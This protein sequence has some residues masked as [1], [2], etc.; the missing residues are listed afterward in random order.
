VQERPLARD[1]RRLAAIVAA[2]AVGYSRLMGHDE[3]G[4]LARLRE[5]RTLRFDPAVARHGGRLV[6]LTGD[7]A[8]VEFGSA[9]DAL[10]AAIEFQQAMAE[11]NRGQPADIVIQFRIGV[12]LGDLIVDSDD[13][14]GEGVNIAAR[15]EAEASAGGIVISRTVH[16]AVEGRLKTGFDSLGPL[17]LK[18]IRRPVQAHRVIWQPSDWSAPVAP[19]TRSA[20]ANPASQKS[21]PSIAVLPFDNMS[22]DAE[23]DYFAD[24]IVDDLITALSRFKSLFVVARNASFTYKGKTVPPQQAGQELGVRYLL[25]G[26]VRKAADRVRITGQLID[27]ETGAHLWADRF[28]GPLN[29]VF[30]L[31]DRVTT[32]VVG[33][34]VP[35][36]AQAEFDRAKRKKF[37]NLDAYDCTLRALAL[38]QQLSKESNEQMLALYNRAIELDPEFSPPH[39]HAVQCYVNM[40]LHGWAFD[41]D[42]HEAEVRRL[43]GRILAIGQDDAVALST[44]ALGL[45]WVCREFEASADYANTATTINPNLA[46]AWKNRGAISVFRGEPE[47]AIEQLSRASR[48]SPIGIDFY[49][50]QGY[51]ALAYLF[52]GEYDKA[53]ECAKDPCLYLTAWPIG[54]MASAAAHGLADNPAAAR[55]SLRRLCRLNSALQLSNLADFLSFH[56]AE[57]L[58]TLTEG[59]RLAGLEK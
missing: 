23:H 42:Q 17:S 33:A 15:L 16:E 7:G 50:V 5:H 29:D 24:G 11:I 43:A 53:A 36:L 52:E 32:S 59:L 14:Y 34:I 12:H 55:R 21:L 57:D 4:T 2:D 47:T 37:E 38:S 39:G 8:L 26:S 46:I 3:S 41:K 19:T 10:A 13:L 35:K 1:R 40:K 25:E 30:D 45:A 31:Q 58:H 49:T 44:V 20:A 48:I 27:T 56:R 28:D 6:K 54:Y 18:N 51:A 22:G 9:V